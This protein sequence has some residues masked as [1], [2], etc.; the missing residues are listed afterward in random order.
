MPSNQSGLVSIVTTTLNEVDTIE[1]LVRNVHQQNYRPLELIVV[2]GGS[3]DG[4]VE[5]VKRL[6]GELNGE[7]FSIRIFRE[8]DFGTQRSSGNAKNIGV[9]VSKGWKVLFLDPDMSFMSNDSVDLISRKLEEVPF[10]KVKTAM[11]LDTDLERLRARGYPRYHHCGYRRTVLEKVQFDASLGFGED[12]DFWFRVKRDLGLNMDE[13]CDAIVARHLPHT[14][15]EYLRQSSWYAGTMTQFA[16]VVIE[17][18]EYEFMGVL[19]DWLRYWSY[20]L[21]PPLAFLLPFFDYARRENNFPVGLSFLLWDSII[22]RYV[23]LYHFLR[24]S[25]KT[26]SLQFSMRLLLACAHIRLSAISGYKLLQSLA[27]TS[28]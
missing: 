28:Q 20:C 24:T 6:I 9:R 2:D 12:Q 25:I 22:R 4:T 21:L 26:N 13:I 11:I 1:T 27:V 7:S 8:K 23:S 15:A 14:K 3:R 17:R 5:K 19:C 18:R 10:T 16:H